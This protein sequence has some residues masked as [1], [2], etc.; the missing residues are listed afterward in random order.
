MPDCVIIQ[1]MKEKLNMKKYLPDKLTKF[2]LFI[3]V[4]SNA[5]MLCRGAEK[6]GSKSILMIIAP[7]KFRDEELLV[8]ERIFKE[9]GI[10]VIVASTTTS[11][12][13][14]MLG[15]EV[16]PDILLKDVKL[17]RYDAVIFVGGVGAQVYYNNSTVQQIARN[18]AGADKTVGAICLAPN[19]LAKAGLLRGRNA[20]C[21]NSG[22]LKENGA[23]YHKKS[24]IKDKN[25]ITACGPKAAIQF[26]NAIL[27][28]LKYNSVCR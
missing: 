17:N 28:E 13:K 2:I 3:I 26:A 27:N 1:N 14:G 20:T 16:R 23:I 15:A 10:K 4:A 18:A 25:I 22:I 19:I 21:W 6:P 12:V 7:D 9:N 8:P 5:V 24:V 11:I